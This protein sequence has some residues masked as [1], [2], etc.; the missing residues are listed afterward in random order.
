MTAHAR[1]LDERPGLIRDLASIRFHWDETYDI[2]VRLTDSGGEEWSARRLDGR[3]TPVR[4]G[5]KGELRIALADDHAAH[6]VPGGINVE[7]F[8]EWMAH[9]VTLRQF[10]GLHEDLGYRMSPQAFRD[11]KILARATA[12]KP[13]S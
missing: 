10:R 8:R 1:P 11:L 3:G 9:R 13:P 2:S 7:R 6:S 5:S 12:K 4:A